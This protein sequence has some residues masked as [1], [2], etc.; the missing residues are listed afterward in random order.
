MT[1]NPS[2]SRHISR[3]LRFCALLIVTACLASCGTYPLGDSHYPHYYGGH[4]SQVGPMG[5]VP[6]EARKSDVWLPLF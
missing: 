5:F 4:G 3:A 1:N 2:F 6:K